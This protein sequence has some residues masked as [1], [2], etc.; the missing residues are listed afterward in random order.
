[1][2]HEVPTEAA[3]THIALA[4]SIRYELKRVNSPPLFQGKQ[5]VIRYNGF[6]ACL[7]NLRLCTFMRDDI[8]QK[9][10]NSVKQLFMQL[11]STDLRAE[12]GAQPV[13]V[14]PL[15]RAS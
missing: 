5:F 7:L 10:I 11:A 12:T 13:F 14:T 3:H 2:G 1:M 6:R 4:A 8:S 15:P 9:L